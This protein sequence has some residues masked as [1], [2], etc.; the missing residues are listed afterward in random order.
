MNEVG[1]YLQKCRKASGATQA[2]VARYLGYESNQYISN[3][4]RG[5]CLPTLWSAEK[6]CECVG[7]N[8]KLLGKL[9]IEAKTHE[10]R[11][12]LG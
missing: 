8:K 9:M 11:E 12:V 3:V 10:I 5:Q 2:D 6:W 7:A 1:K 4:E